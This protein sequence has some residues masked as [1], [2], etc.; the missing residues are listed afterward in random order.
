MDASTENMEAKEAQEAFMREF[1]AED[2]RRVFPR[3]THPDIDHTTSPGK[4]FDGEGISAVPEQPAS[5]VSRTRAA[6]EL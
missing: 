3:N 5:G 2:I 4:P 6:A 1:P